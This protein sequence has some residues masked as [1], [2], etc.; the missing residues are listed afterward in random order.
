MAPPLA[1]QSALVTGASQGIGLATAVA[2]ADAG[3]SVAFNYRQNPGEATAAAEAIN[4]RGGRA[5]VLAGDVA[6]Q[7]TVERLVADTV[8]AFG[9]LDIAVTNA[10]Y[11]DREPFWQADMEGFRRTIDV[12]MWG[13][14]YLVRAAAQQMLAQPQANRPARGSIVVVSSPHAYTAVPRSM[15]YNMAKAAI[16]QM[17]RTAAIELAEHK[18]RVNIMTPGWIDTPGERKFA[19]DET[20]RNSGTK[21]PWQR[22][23]TAQEIGRGVVFLCDPAS[24]YITGSWLTIDGG[25]TLPWWANRGSGVPE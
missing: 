11:S 13:A 4:H 23:G 22:L 18:V 9:R 20:I 7:S 15:A 1:G 6:D 24:D 3:A 5:I 19:S 12:T 25:I 14:F 16:D 10:A 8:A 17:A 21:L 2:L